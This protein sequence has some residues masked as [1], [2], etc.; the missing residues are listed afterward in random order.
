MKS[1]RQCAQ[2]GVTER[3]EETEKKRGGERRE[4]RTT[5]GW[6]DGETEGSDREKS[7][8]TKGEGERDERAREG[9]RVHENTAH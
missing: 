3:E 9:G 4:R 2:E 8:N 6:K 7:G 1:V 5:R